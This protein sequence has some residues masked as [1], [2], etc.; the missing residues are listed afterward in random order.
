MVSRPDFKWE[1]IAFFPVELNLRGVRCHLN[2]ETGEWFRVGHNAPTE[3]P[4]IRQLQENLNTLKLKN[5]ILLDMITAKE[6]DRT[7][8]TKLKAEL[9]EL[10]S[11]ER[12]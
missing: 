11:K 2:P 6:L 10:V 1:D 7:E 3:S 9:E 5:D 4:E 8:A 12:T